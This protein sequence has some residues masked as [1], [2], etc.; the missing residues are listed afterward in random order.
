MLLIADSGTSKTDWLLSD[1]KQESLL[2]RTPGL[3][4]FFLNEREMVKLIHHHGPGLLSYADHV[5]E[6]YFFGAGC[7]DPDRREL[8]SNVLSQIFEKAF[9]SVDSD[10]KGSA[11]A[12]C[13]NQSGFCCVIGTG[14]NIAFFD[15][16]ELHNGKHGLGYVLGD[17]GSGCAIGKRLVTD[18]LY[19]KMPAHIHSRFQKAYG[20]TK[21]IIVRN[22]YLKAGANFYLGSFSRFLNEIRPEEYAQ[23]V[24][25]DAFTMFVLTHIKPYP[26]NEN[27]LFNFV[28]SIAFVFQQELREV[29][30]IHNIGVGKIIHQPVFELEKHI[31][32]QPSF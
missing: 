12:T 3:N 10:L 17:E 28:G 30:D 13:G 27:H 2:F 6:I 19:G 7:S 24:I 4:P 32:S 22:M 25:K 31:I 26:D 8:I 11:Y 29:C 14:S 20:L 21:E 18:F 16:E 23:S 5:T 1:P 9:I 15:G